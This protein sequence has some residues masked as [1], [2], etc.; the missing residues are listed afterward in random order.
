VLNE[1]IDDLLALAMG[2]PEDMASLYVDDVGGV[3]VASVKLTEVLCLPLG[4]GEL[5]VQGVHFL[6]AFQ[7]DRFDCVLA[8]TS[9][10]S[11]LLEVVGSDG[12]K[13]PSVLQKW[14]R[15]PMTLCL[16]GHL[17]DSGDPAG[18]AQ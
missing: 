16:K 13:I 1:V 15:D 2:D 9:N 3:L 11:D 4:L 5:A 10:L 17:L 8:K 18:W 7:V 6:Q 14:L 12:E